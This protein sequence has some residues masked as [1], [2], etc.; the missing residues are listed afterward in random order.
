MST[1]SGS[2][3]DSHA[4]RSY[5]IARLF[6]QPLS[7]ARPVGEPNCSLNAQTD[8]PG[9]VAVL[10][11]EQ[12][13]SYARWLIRIPTPRPNDGKLSYNWHRF[14]YWVGKPVSFCDFCEAT[15]ITVPGL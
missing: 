1:L 13:A 11:G 12:Q 2:S 15:P 7:N 3:A 14:T 5:T 4:E 9:R 6:P 8:R 10:A